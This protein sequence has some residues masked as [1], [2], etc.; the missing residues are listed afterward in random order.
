MT[1]E[2]LIDSNFFL[3]LQP[4]F[5]FQVTPSLF[6]LLGNSLLQDGKDITCTCLRVVCLGAEPFPSIAELRKFI[7]KPHTIELYNIYGISEVSSWASVERVD[8]YSMDFASGSIDF[9]EEECLQKHQYDEDLVHREVSIGLPLSDTKIEL[10]SEHGAVLLEGYGEIW[11][12]TYLF[13]L[14]LP[15][16]VILSSIIELFYMC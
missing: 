12:G 2:L 5:A 4:V 13:C 7:K 11:I 3:F 6:H 9:L 16:T 10:R 15:I 8:L 14:L 1:D